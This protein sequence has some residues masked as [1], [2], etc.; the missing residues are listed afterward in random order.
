MPLNARRRTDT[1]QNH[2]T[3][4]EIE[5]SHPILKSKTI[6]MIAEETEI[7]GMRGTTTKMVV[8]KTTATEETIHIVAE[9]VAEIEMPAEPRKVDPYRYLQFSNRLINLL[10]TFSHAE[11]EPTSAQDREA[12]TETVPAQR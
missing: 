2:A 4:S 11:T 12:Q 1:G 10:Q 6:V 7:G 9:T 8:E 5:K 3:G